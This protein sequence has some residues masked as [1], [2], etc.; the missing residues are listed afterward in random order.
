VIVC[1]GCNETLSSSVRS[2]C[3]S[4]K[5]VTPAVCSVLDLVLSIKAGQ[6]LLSKKSDYSHD[7]NLSKSELLLC[8]N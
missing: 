1:V 3:G 6:C 5:L 7:P 4:G 2:E 8:I